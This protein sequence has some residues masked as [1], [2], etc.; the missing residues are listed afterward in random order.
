MIEPMKSQIT[1]YNDNIKNDKLKKK[2]RFNV[3]KNFVNGDVKS[4][5]SLKGVLTKSP[6]LKFRRRTKIKDRITEMSIKFAGKAENLMASDQL[7]QEA[8]MHPAY[9]D[10]Y[11]VWSVGSHQFGQNDKYLSNLFQ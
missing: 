11:N 1:E 6:D 5:K 10:K 7:T 2:I 3:M 9:S 8:K 4:L